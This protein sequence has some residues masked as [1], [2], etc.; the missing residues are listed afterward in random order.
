[1]GTKTF[2]LFIIFLLFTVFVQ[3]LILEILEQHN[4]FGLVLLEGDCH[5]AAASPNVLIA[6]MACG[7]VPPLAKPPLESLSA[8]KTGVFPELVLSS[9]VF[10]C[11]WPAA[12]QN[13]AAAHNQLPIATVRF[14]TFPFL[15][16]EHIAQHAFRS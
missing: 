6:S 5:V 14:I 15:R 7:R 3:K 2:F 9:L 11:C 10:P 4:I 12:V 13:N 16:K 8:T 1:M